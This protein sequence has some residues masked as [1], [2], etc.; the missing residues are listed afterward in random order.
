MEKSCSKCAPKASPRF[1]FYFGKQPKTAIA[2]KNFFENKIFWKEIIKPSK[3][4]LSP[5][6]FWWTKLSKT[7]GAWNKWPVLLQVI[8]FISYI[9]SDQVWWCNIQ[10]FLSY[11]KNYTCKCMQVNAWH[12]W[13]F[14]FHLFFWIWK[15]VERKRKKY[16]KMNISGTKRAF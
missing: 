16:N 10:R 1:L 9:L 11:S 15:K 13:L 12:H 6:P 14:H 5:R 7:K 4:K 3:I 2:C 8:K